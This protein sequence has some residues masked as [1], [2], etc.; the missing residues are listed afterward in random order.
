MQQLHRDKHQQAYLMYGQGS[1]HA[2]YAYIHTYA[3]S[4]YGAT[5]HEFP[6]PQKQFSSPA[7]PCELVELCDVNVLWHSLQACKIKQG[8]PKEEPY[9]LKLWFPLFHIRQDVESCFLRHSHM[10]THTDIYTMLNH[11]KCRV[12]IMHLCFFHS[13]QHVLVSWQGSRYYLDTCSVV[14]L[15]FIFLFCV[16]SGATVGLSLNHP[17]FALRPSPF[18]VFTAC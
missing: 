5:V 3:D 12:C 17:P 6:N 7:W 4:V 2:F 15:A 8:L 10:H 1:I 11:W 13:E 18:F 9:I 16:F 14:T